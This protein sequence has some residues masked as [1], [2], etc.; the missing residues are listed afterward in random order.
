MNE[1]LHRTT[2]EPEPADAIGE[3]ELA[4][5]TFAGARA[6]ALMGLTLA[7]SAF[8]AIT[9]TLASTTVSVK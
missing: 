4:P 3:M 9:P 1:S 7:T 5:K 8:A 2:A 6:R